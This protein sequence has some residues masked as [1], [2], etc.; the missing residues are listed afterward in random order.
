MTAT[1]YTHTVRGKYRIRTWL[2]GRLS[3]S[4]AESIP[5]GEDCGAHQWYRQSA[6]FDACY[7]CRVTRPHEAM[8]P[9]DTLLADL[10]HATR[11]GSAAAQSVLL[12]RIRDGLRPCRP[13]RPPRRGSVWPS[14]WRLIGHDRYRP[15]RGS[16]CRAPGAL[17]GTTAPEVERGIC[18]RQEPQSAWHRPPLSEGRPLVWTVVRAREARQAFPWPDQAAGRQRR[19]DAAPGPGTD[20]QGHGRDRVRSRTREWLSR[21]GGCC[22]GGWGRFGA[23]P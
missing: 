21:K 14:T 22:P 5:K 23:C 17:S 1:T 4:L 13:E 15:Q 18:A 2:R 9:A 7:H 8:T 19:P 12:A 10:E 3:W 20:G 16:V 6:E 11:A